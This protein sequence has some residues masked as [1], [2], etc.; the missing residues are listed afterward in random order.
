M[1]ESKL[2]ARY[3]KALLEIAIEKK[4]LDKVHQDILS[5]QQASESREFVLMLK[6]P[7][8][9]ESK[10]LSVL[11]R[12]FGSGISEITASFFKIVVRKGRESY[13]IGLADE[14][15]KQY[16]KHNEILTATFTTAVKVEDTIIESIKG[17]LKKST[18]MKEVALEAQVDENIIGGF[19]LQYRDNLLD[20]SVSGK[21]NTLKKQF[22]D[23]SYI[24]SI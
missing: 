24:K 19:V 4:E 5:F 13:L 10:K 23:K 15:I 18:S 17:L 21:L 2:A 22:T 8:I 12:I 20:A 14:F 3:A 11:N 1:R 9:N 6:S 7:I 16:N